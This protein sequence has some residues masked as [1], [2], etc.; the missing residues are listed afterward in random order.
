MGRDCPELHQPEIPKQVRYLWRWY[1]EL[2]Q[3]KQH[4]GMSY[5]PLSWQEM[6]A[7]ATLTRRNLAEWEVYALRIIDMVQL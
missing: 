6:Q 4:N 1:C 7:W 5:S 3:G 2:S